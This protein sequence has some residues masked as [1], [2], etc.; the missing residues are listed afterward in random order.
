MRRGRYWTLIATVVLGV[1]FGT[2]SFVSNAS[3]VLIT[4]SS[5]TTFITGNNPNAANGS[6][7]VQVDYAIYD[8]TSLT[9]PKGLTSD[10]QISL[11]LTS[12]A[13]PW[14]GQ[15]LPALK[16]GRLTVYAPDTH[17][18]GAFYTKPP[19]STDLE[20]RDNSIVST[21]PGNRTPRR[22]YFYTYVAGPPVVL[23]SVDFWFTDLASL[24]QFLP[25]DI[26]KQLILRTPASNLSSSPTIN[27][28]IDT[29][30]AGTPGGV[31][32]EGSITL[33]P[34]PEPCSMAIFGGAFAL[35]YLRRNGR[36]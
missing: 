26:S 25:G 35:L 21:S 3:A 11:T 7:K 12:L 19:G 2:S 13:T 23:N 16:F 15:E 10:A 24:P 1:I 14:A 29:T 17:N 30:N 28:Q 20:V 6:F 4:G 8:G 22:V 32:G 36:K 27:L 9:D 33:V 34:V 5:G 18:T 31:Y